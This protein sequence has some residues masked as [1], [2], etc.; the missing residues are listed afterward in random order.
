M[1]RIVQLQ[2]YEYD[3]LVEQAQK[4][5]EAIK[6]EALRLYKEHGVA[7]VKVSI[8]TTDRNNGDRDLNTFVYVCKD[9]HWCGDDAITD[10]M[11]QD[12]ERDIK[13]SVSRIVEMKYGKNIADTNYCRR[14]VRKVERRS[15]LIDI[16]SVLGWV[17]TFIAVLFLIVK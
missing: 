17:F 6:Q 13:D 14:M 12:I 2:A 4:N 8:N 3:K 1:E 5:E 16:L 7:E 9:Y 11:K 15:A 10:E